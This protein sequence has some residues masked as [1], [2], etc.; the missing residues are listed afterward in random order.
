MSGK[1]LSFFGEPALKAAVRRRVAEHQ[2]LDQI[3][4]GVYWDDHRFR[5]CFIGCSLHSRFYSDFER[6]LGL[7]TWLARLGERVFEC[8][9]R[10][11]AVRF[12]LRLYDAIPVGVDLTPVRHAFLAWLVREYCVPHDRR[13]VAVALA[14][15]AALRGDPDWPAER[16]AADDRVR[17]AVEA[18]DY[19]ASDVACI[20]RN[21]IAEDDEDFV[22]DNTVYAFG[23][24][25][26]AASGDK[27]IAL[28]AA[29]PDA[30]VEA[31]LPDDPAFAAYYDAVLAEQVA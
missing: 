1:L 14:H 3:T 31:H 28:C 10:V 9:D 22:V 5:G 21:A 7:P 11:Y 18:A 25:A 29:I 30:A 8:L 19:R 13:H 27:L 26:A 23:D 17:E 2:R 15:E 16:A 4:Q 12:P 6:L 24:V 20:A